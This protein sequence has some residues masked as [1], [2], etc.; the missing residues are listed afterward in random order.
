[1]KWA[2]AGMVLLAGGAACAGHAPPEGAGPLARYDILVPG[3]DSLSGAIAAVFS[4]MG[5]VVRD[6]VRGGGRPTAA[7][8]FWRYTDPA[9]RGALEAELADTRRGTVLATTTVPGDTLRGDL[10]ARALL[11]VRGL[12][13]PSP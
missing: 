6:E 11:I 7:L 5:F 13:T 4:R 9:G 12:V 10:P 3:R 1:M 8:V 2:A